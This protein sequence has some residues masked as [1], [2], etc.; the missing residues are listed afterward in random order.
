MRPEKGKI[1]SP[2]TRRKD[3]GREFQGVMHRGDVDL[4]VPRRP[5]ANSNQFFQPTIIR[6]R[7]CLHCFATTDGGLEDEATISIG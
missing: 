1:R 4:D 2:G 6:R 5:C 7:L 3:E